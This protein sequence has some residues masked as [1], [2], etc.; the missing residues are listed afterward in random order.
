[1]QIELTSAT[2]DVVVAVTGVRSSHV[3]NTEQCALPKR[4]RSEIGK[5]NTTPEVPV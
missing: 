5:K 2:E 1:M 3:A 4:V